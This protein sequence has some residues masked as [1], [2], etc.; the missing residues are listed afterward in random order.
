MERHAKEELDN[1]IRYNEN[2]NYKD[3]LMEELYKY[4]RTEMMLRDFNNVVNTAYYRNLGVFNTRLTFVWDGLGSLDNILLG[5]I[6]K[7]FLNI[8]EKY[9][10]RKN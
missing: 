7:D 9:Q 8:F 3:N 6:P 4:T 2:F 10:K 1:L 5:W